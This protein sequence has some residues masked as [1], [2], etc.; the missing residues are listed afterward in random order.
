MTASTLLA[1]LRRRGVL[2]VPEGTGL[3]YR[4]P[5]GILT[6]TDRAALRAHRDELLA[7]LRD[8]RAEILTS[9]EPLP[10]AEAAADVVALLAADAVSETPLLPDAAD[11]VADAAVAIT[12]ALAGDGWVGVWSRALAAEVLFARDVDVAVPPPFAA[13]PRFD[14]AELAVL[15]AER[16]SASR[17]QAICDVKREMSGTRVVRSRE[18]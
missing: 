7:L 16:P 17:L 9:G 5:R 4:A 3:R 18:Q 10:D 1:D 6:D 8:P 14:L 2:L 11:A 12:R 15:A 13:L